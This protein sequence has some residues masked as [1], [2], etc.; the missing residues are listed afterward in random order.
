M[1]CAAVLVNTGN[2]TDDR[3]EVTEPDGKKIVLARGESCPVIAEH[4]DGKSF[5]V[6]ALPPDPDRPGRY[7]DNPQVIVADRP[8]KS[9]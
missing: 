2:C 4:G 7:V 1:T 6:R 8:S 3:I 5:A 9:C